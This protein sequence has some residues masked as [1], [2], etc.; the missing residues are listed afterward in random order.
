MIY[1]SQK[2]VGSETIRSFHCLPDEIQFYNLTVCSLLENNRLPEKISIIFLWDQFC[3]LLLRWH[4]K[5][6]NNKTD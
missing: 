2:L 6:E 1:L 4:G 5:R 3:S